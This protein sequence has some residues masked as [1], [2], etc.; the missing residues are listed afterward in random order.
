M[1]S[2]I[3]SIQMCSSTSI[4]ENLKQAQLLILQA[5]SKQA[6]L[7][8]LPE[9][10]AI[11]GHSGLDKVWEKER[12]G[13]GKIQSFLSDQARK[14]QLWIVGGSIPLACDDENKV[15]ASTLVFNAEGVCVARY[16]KIHLFDVVISDTEGYQESETTEPG[17]NVCIVDSPFGRIGLAICY[18]IRFPELF[19]YMFN[20]GVEILIVPAAFTQTT[21]EAHW[22]ILAKSRAIENFCYFIG[23]CQGGT[24]SNGRTTYG[25]S[26]IID[27]WGTIL[28]KKETLD[29]GF[30]CATID[31]KKTH[32]LRNSIPVQAHQRIFFDVSQMGW[33]KWKE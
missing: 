13:L 19:R 33:I 29:P 23:S 26:L 24:H 5:K 8:V 27:P 10:F 25:H 3:A 12:F 14:N 4:D 21:G 31:L 17:N 18:D 20:Q 15:R 30:I 9:M 22:E 1:L 16:D 11:M 32:A 2:T 7:V 6:Q 28:A